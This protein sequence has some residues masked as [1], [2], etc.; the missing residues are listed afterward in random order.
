MKLSKEASKNL[1][2]NLLHPDVEAIKKRDE[3]LSSINQEV[4]QNVDGTTTVICHD[5]DLD[6]IT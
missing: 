1:I 3:F 6:D 4:I 5:L 2:Y